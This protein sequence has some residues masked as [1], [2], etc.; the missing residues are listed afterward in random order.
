MNDEVREMGYSSNVNNHAGEEKVDLV[1]E[2][3]M[4]VKHNY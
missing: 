4:A 1:C 3:G 2:I